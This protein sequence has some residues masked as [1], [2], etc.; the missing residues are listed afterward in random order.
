[1]ESADMTCMLE[2]GTITYE[3]GDGRSTIDLCWTTLGMVDRIINSRVD[4]NLDHNSDHLPIS[5]VMDVRTSLMEAKPNDHGNT[6]T[7]KSSARSSKRHCRH[8]GDQEHEAALDSCMR[9]LVIAITR[10]PKRYSL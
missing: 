4:R 7:P 3:E 1:M 6:W 8:G 9:D 5:I 2:P 10:P